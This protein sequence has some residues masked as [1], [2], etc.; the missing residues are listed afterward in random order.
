VI[1]P[2]EKLILFL[3]NPLLI[4]P[5]LSLI[6]VL[7][8]YQVQERYFVYSYRTFFLLFLENR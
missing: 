7:K 6:D 2:V 5:L 3:D 4:L 8:D 1:L